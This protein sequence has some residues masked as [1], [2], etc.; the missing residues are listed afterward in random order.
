[1]VAC[2]DVPLDGGVEPSDAVGERDGAVE[3]YLRYRLGCEG[4]TWEGKKVRT[5]DPWRTRWSACTRKP[6]DEP[7]SSTPATSWPG[8]TAAPPTTPQTTTAHHPRV[9][10]RITLCGDRPFGIAH[11]TGCGES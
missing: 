4:N 8:T 10:H 11:P 5:L 3:E 9:M 6:A 7:C 1:M 2:L